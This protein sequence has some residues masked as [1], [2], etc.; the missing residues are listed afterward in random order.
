MMKGGAPY[1]QMLGK[2]S[3]PPGS[4]TQNPMPGTPMG[5]GRFMGGPVPRVA[6][7][8]LRTFNAGGGQTAYNPFQQLGVVRPGQFTPRIAEGG[9]MGPNVGIPQDMPMIASA[10]DYAFGGS[11]AGPKVPQVAPQDF[12][13]RLLMQSV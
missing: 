11:P 8:P 1:A 7:P 6:V 3:P 4:V 12:M 5:A 2:M 13:Q 9:L 10:P